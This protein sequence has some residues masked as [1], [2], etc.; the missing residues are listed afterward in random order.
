[1][2]FNLRCGTH[3]DLAAAGSVSRTDA[4]FAQNIGTGRE[5]RAFDVFH[6][7]LYF[8]FLVID[9][10]LNHADNPIDD[11]TQIM[12]RNI[13][14]HTDSDT[15]GTV[16]QKVGDTGRQYR[17]FFFVFVIVR[18]EINGI[19]F[20]IRQHFRCD[21]GHAGFGITAGSCAIAVDRTKVP[22]TV[23]QHITHGEILRHTYHG[24]INGGIP[25]GVIFTHGIAD[26]TGGFTIA[27]VGV[28]I[29]FVHGIQDTTLH[30]LQAVTGIGQCTGNNYT[31]GIVDIAFLHFLVDVYRNDLVDLSVF[32]FITHKFT[33]FFLGRCPKPCKGVTPLTRF[34][35]TIVSARN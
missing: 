5:V 29:H 27:L 4:A 11:L 17:R 33:S 32:I 13:G 21:L 18:N 8:C 19:F 31:H 12:G 26:D 1:M 2:F 28:Q 7:F 23:Y 22:M 10:V 14:R 9:L 24:L 16:H 6:Q 30:G 20:D 25:V 35:E 3:N 15:A 34:A